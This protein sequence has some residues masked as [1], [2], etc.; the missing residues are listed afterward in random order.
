MADELVPVN[1]N[2]P[3]TLALLEE[4]SGVGTEHVDQT[5]LVIPRLQVKHQRQQ[6]VNPQTNEVYDEL[7]VVL[8]GLIK[9]RTLWRPQLSDE[10]QL[11]LCRSYDY[12]HGYP[13]D[14]NEFPWEESGFPMGT[15]QPLPCANCQLKDWGSHPVNTGKPWCQEQHTYPLLII[16]EDGS[17]T[18]MIFT[19]AKT[20]LTPSRNYVSYFVTNKRPMLS[21]ITRLTLDGAKKGG[22]E[23]SIPRFERLGPSD[24]SQWRYW[25]DQWQ[26]INDMLTAPRAA[27]VTTDDEQPVAA[28]AREPRQPAAPAKDLWAED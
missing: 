12:D 26:K 25:A 4:L 28:P 18:P 8:L 17:Y 15:P 9:Q 14:D 1:E 2:D 6:F 23:Y 20:G 16:G 13:P 21:V 19:V 22:N 3:A 5:D 7:E 11:P 10:G 27:D 24:S